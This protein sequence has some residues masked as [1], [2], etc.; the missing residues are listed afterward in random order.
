MNY[1][2]DDRFHYI[3]VDGRNKKKNMQLDIIPNR[4]EQEAEKKLSMINVVDGKFDSFFDVNKGVWSQNYT[5]LKIYLDNKLLSYYSAEAKKLQAQDPD[6]ELGIKKLSSLANNEAQRL[7]K[8]V[9]PHFDPQWPKGLPNVRDIEGLDGRPIGKKIVYDSI[10]NFNGKR[11]D[12]TD[13]KPEDFSTFKLPYT[14]EHGDMRAF[15]KIMKTFYKEEDYELILWLIGMVATGNTLKNDRM[16]FVYGK[17]GTGKGT[18]LDII[19]IIFKGYAQPM[20]MKRF[21]SDYDFSTLFGPKGLISID[22]DGD[23]SKLSD[24]DDLFNATSHEPYAFM[25]KGKSPY[26][27]TYSGVILMATNKLPYI[28]VGGG[29]ARRIFFLETTGNRIE[30]MTGD[31]SN[32]DILVSK[33][34]KN[35]IPAI[36]QAGI[37]TWNRL[38]AYH[39]KNYDPSEYLVRSDYFSALIEELRDTLDMN[40]K[41]DTFMGKPVFTTTSK[42]VK[43]AKSKRLIRFDDFFE[44][45]QSHME[46]QKVRGKGKSEVIESLHRYGHGIKYLGTS[47]DE[48]VYL[49]EIKRQEGKLIMIDTDFYSG[50]D[51]DNIKE[52]KNSLTG[53]VEL[54]VDRDNLKDNNVEVTD[55]LI[56]EILHQEPEHEIIEP[57]TA[58]HD[59]IEKAKKANVVIIKAEEPTS[60]EFID[61]MFGYT[62]YPELLEKMGEP[63]V[64]DDD[65]EPDPDGEVPKPKP[66]PKKDEPKPLNYP[67]LGKEG[68]NKFYG[69]YNIMGTEGAKDHVSHYYD[70]YDEFM[71]TYDPIG[72]FK[73]LYSDI[74]EYMK[75][76]KIDYDENDFDENGHETKFGLA[77]RMAQS[78]RMTKEMGWVYFGELDKPYQAQD[79]YEIDF[80]DNGS[81]P[82]Y[83]LANGKDHFHNYII[84]AKNRIYPDMKYGWLKPTQSFLDAYKDD[85]KMDQWNFYERVGYTEDD[86]IDRVPDF[87]GPN[88]IDT[89]EAKKGLKDN[90]WDIHHVKE[91]E[92]IEAEIVDEEPKADPLADLDMEA[93]AEEVSTGWVTKD[94]K[95]GFNHKNTAH[96]N[97]FLQEWHKAGR[98]RN[99]KTGGQVMVDY[100]I[101]DLYVNLPKLDP[102]KFDT[103]VYFQLVPLNIIMI[104]VDFDDLDEG[105]AYVEEHYPHSYVEFS[106]SGRL[107]VI[108]KTSLDRENVKLGTIVDLGSS[109]GKKRIIEQKMYTGNEAM[110][111]NMFTTANDSEIMPLNSDLIEKRYNTTSDTVEDERHLKNKINWALN[112]WDAPTQNKISL[113]VNKIKEAYEVL[114]E[115]DVTEFNADVYN[116]AYH[117]TNSSQRDLKMLREVDGMWKKEKED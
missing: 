3:T 116:L 8:G 71:K 91:A 34:K 74:P 104:D 1:E 50:N 32:Y 93:L 88:I 117:A 102:S 69:E 72:S 114:E 94:L 109:D 79:E 97:K 103:S 73:E 46:Q 92:P 31:Q 113:I 106:R 68:F 20:K 6:I 83:Y 48:R 29:L 55:D 67:E 86:I 87:Y 99:A 2:L 38:G 33:I 13:I 58:V 28:E 107:H 11:Y 18:L 25:E 24:N 64:I 19:S 100:D 81:D 115:Y 39:Y 41:L 105:I 98:V 42:H 26:N 56:D 53:D 66:K 77:K 54:V 7:I 40:P 15:E 110:L 21:L 57:S 70:Y 62:E 89:D 61:A 95:D 47:N 45:Y 111:R 12:G 78:Y 37:D 17:G 76:G 51:D 5:N 14:P 9:W 85:E 90:Y 65:P 112:K 59:A 60:V 63:T 49:S 4:S 35:E 108:Y 52:Q 10:V 96:L 75:L 30:G 84:R 80:T 44:I 22:Y 101:K 27:F 43:G 36:V 16:F 82:Q 23:G